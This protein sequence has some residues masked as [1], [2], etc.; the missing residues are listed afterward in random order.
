MRAQII[1]TALL[2]FSGVAFADEKSKPA[3][4]EE[5]KELKLGK[6]R[7]QECRKHFAEGK[8]NEAME[9]AQQSLEIFVAPY[10]ELRNLGIGVIDTEEYRIE[11]HVNTSEAER[12]D[13][14]PPITRPY[15]FVVYSKGDEPKFLYSLDFEHG[16]D[17]GKL[18]SAALGRMHG[19]HINYGMVKTDAKFSEVKAR[20]LEVIKS[21]IETK[22]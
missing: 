16:H 22:D 9:L 13:P 10:P 1:I 19:G 12:A 6:E 15:S 3:V 8:E 4:S 20:A 5:S 17:D 2:A 21:S 7:L 18:A 11:V 14:K